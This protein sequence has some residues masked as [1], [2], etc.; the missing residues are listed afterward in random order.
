MSDSRTI[1]FQYAPSITFTSICRTDDFYKTLV[2]DDGSLLYGF[3]DD[4]YQARHFER[5]VEFGIQTAHAPIRISQKTES[6]RVPVVV[7]TLEYARATLELRTFA[8]VHDGDLR[9]DVVLWT[10][11]AND[12]VDE[13][14]TGIKLDAYERRHIFIGRSSP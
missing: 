10:I 9:T 13:I 1:H 2:R 7:T 11:R 5:V 3:R 14:L 4:G 8:H 6:A 12:D